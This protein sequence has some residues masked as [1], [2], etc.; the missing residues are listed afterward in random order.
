MKKF[1]FVL[2][3]AIVMVFLNF[4]VELITFGMGR[5]QNYKLIKYASNHMVLF[6]IIYILRLF[7]MQFIIFRLNGKLKISI[8]GV[9]FLSVLN[10]YLLLQSFLSLVAGVEHLK[11]LAP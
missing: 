11:L 1:I 6:V 10:L 9:V 8:V 2:V 4:Y 3:I 7:V 5:C